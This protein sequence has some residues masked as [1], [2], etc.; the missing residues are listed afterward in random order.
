[1]GAMFRCSQERAFSGRPFPVSERNR[2][3]LSSSTS[4]V[5]VAEQFVIVL[6]E[7]G[8]FIRDRNAAN[9]ADIQ[10]LLAVNLFGEVHAPGPV[11]AFVPMSLHAVKQHPRV[12]V[13]GL[14]QQRD[15]PAFR[16][17]HGYD[18]PR[19]H[20]GGSS[21]ELAEKSQAK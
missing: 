1:M 8:H 2:V 13:G 21:P 18:L 12:G 6:A 10:H 20:R 4:T 3:C 15:P 9:P 19:P 16:R 14:H 7:D 5:Q 11:I 17:R